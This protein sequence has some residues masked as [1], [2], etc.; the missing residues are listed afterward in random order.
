MGMVAAGGVDGLMTDESVVQNRMTDKPELDDL[1]AS[2]ERPSWWTRTSQRLVRSVR[3]STGVTVL[4][5][6]AIVAV[7]AL[8]LLFLGS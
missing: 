4:L 5:A 8:G 1:R 6:L 3:S 7:I 2:S